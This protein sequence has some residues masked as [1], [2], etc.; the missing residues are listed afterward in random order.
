MSEDKEKEEAGSA[1]ICI[2]GM[3]MVSALGCE[4]GPVLARLRQ[5]E[6]MLGHSGAS[7]DRPAHRYRLGEVAEFEVARHLNPVR[8]R[9]MDPVN[10]YTI[11]AS[12]MALA[13]G[14]LDGEA[15]P[16]LGIVVGTGY[17]GLGSA[18]EHTRKLQEQGI[19]KLTPIHFPGTVFN[20]S[21]GL[22]A[23]ELGL[24]GPN[25]TVTGV[26]LPGEYALLQGEMLVRH[27]SVPSIVVTGADDLPGCQFRLMGHWKLLSADPAHA[28]VAHAARFRGATASQGGASLVIE[29]ATAAAAR[30]AAPLAFIE[31][32]GM[33]SEADRVFG[34]SGQTR[35]LHAAIDQALHQAG[36]GERDIAWVSSAANGLPAIDALEARLYRERFHATRP[37]LVS[38]KSYV[39]EFASSGVLRLALGIHCTRQGWLPGLPRDASA[40]WVPTDL[41]IPRQAQALTGRRFLHLGIGIGGA[42]MALVLRATA[43][44][45][46]L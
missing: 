23:I 37:A 17:S 40:D 35:A 12:R 28:A 8:A 38:F 7:D 44:K 34:H 26:D 15:S 21:A 18:Y 24:T 9:R 16:D 27:G 13:Q 1:A 11:A 4:A 43:A 2:T 5:G 6:R 39:G 41:N 22:A 10:L 31:G 20:A 29:D 30:G 3:G 19:A 42:A 45:E 32:M 14:R 46:D 33:A 25:S 36:I